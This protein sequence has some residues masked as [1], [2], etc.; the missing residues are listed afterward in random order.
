[1]EPVRTY[2][3]LDRKEKLFGIEVADF[4]I[5]AL[6]Y[7]AVFIFSTNIFANLGIV[8]ACYIALRLYKKGKPPQYTIMLIRFLLTPK[9]YTLP[10]RE[11]NDKPGTRP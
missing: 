11:K 4:L 8:S 9:F 7:A 10:G 2:T 5:L 1:M 3:Y 6:V